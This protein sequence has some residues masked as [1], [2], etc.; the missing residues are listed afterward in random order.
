MEA[1][2]NVV[3]DR[4]TYGNGTAV[5]EVEVD[6]R[7]AAVKVTPVALIARRRRGSLVMVGRSRIPARAGRAAGMLAS[8]LM[9]RAASARTHSSL[10]SRKR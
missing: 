9:A 3:I 4:M 7:T 8:S 2:E 5:A 10:S 6:I 1:T